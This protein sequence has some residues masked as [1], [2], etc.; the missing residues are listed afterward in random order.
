V[1]GHTPGAIHLYDHDRA[2]A[3]FAQAISGSYYHIKSLEDFQG[4]A[5]H[6]AGQ[7][8]HD[9]GVLYLPAT[10]DRYT[11]PAR[12][13]ALYRLM[14][15]HQICHL[16]FGAHRFDILSARERSPALAARALPEA[17]LPESDFETLYRCFPAPWL[18][19][20][21]FRL[22][23]ATR[24]DAC[25]LRAYPGTRRDY[26][27]I[28]A[29]ELTQR[30]SLEI[31]ETLAGASEAMVRWSLGESTEALAARDGTGV[32]R[33]LLDTAT[34]V[35]APDADVYT[36]ADVLARWYMAVEL[37]G[38]APRTSTDMA[39]PMPVEDVAEDAAFEID[40]VTFHGDPPAEWLQREER[41]ADWREQHDAMNE[42]LALDAA[43]AASDTLSGAL[44]DDAVPTTDTRPTAADV[45]K[46]ELERDVL[47]RRISIEE[48]RIEHALGRNEHH[49]GP[50]YLYDEWDCIAQRYRR[51]W[52]RVF[53]EPAL[54]TDPAQVRA[55]LQR[56]A[57]HQADVRRRFE[58]MKP[59]AYQ[60]VYRIVDGEELDFDQLVDYQTER[61][62]GQLPD[63]RVYSRRDRLHRDVAAAFLVDLSASTDDP[64]E[65]PVPVYATDTADPRGLNLRDPYD[66]QSGA[67]VGAPATRPEDAQ[68]PRRIIDIQR[69]SLVLMAQALDALGDPYAI[70]GFSGYG[71]DNVEFY[72]AKEFRD[73]FDYRTLAALAAMKPRRSTR[74]G[75]AIRHSIHKLKQS[76][77]ALKVLIVI[78]DGFPQDCDYGPDRADHGYGVEDTARA[79]READELGIET[80]CVTVDRSGHDYLKRMCPD[81]RYMVI[82]EIESLPGALSK[83][84]ERLT[85]R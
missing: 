83:V 62:R 58:Q 46:R 35:R 44:P 32:V 42:G 47:A 84:Y 66:E 19:R 71:R 59:F 61:K 82:E 54:D 72:V 73:A 31:V 60:R 50:S 8:L 74:M 78:S 10:L 52:C 5:A 2:L 57:P 20:Q 13:R 15:L 67:P 70:Y 36:S 37:A 64:I 63:D 11:D 9:R 68:S 25:M 26:R 51:G 22:L 34:R 29:L 17:G 18:A 48:S 24:I 81:A 77:S 53:E 21:W 40:P 14:T 38:L 65:K 49:R 3:M 33:A 12:N 85:Q 41:L 55:M 76:A 69:E 43:R 80:F 4:S 79:L 1:N 30:D 28:A 16:E 45:R 6:Q 27:R 56:V 7:P 75:P 39:G 23:E